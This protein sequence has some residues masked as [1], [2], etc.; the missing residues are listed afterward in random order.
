MWIFYRADAIK[1]FVSLTQL[2]G[3]RVN[4]GMR[5]SGTPGL[6]NRLLAANQVD[7]DELTRSSTSDQEAVLALL[8]GRLDALFLVA[9]PEAPYVQML[10]QTPGATLRV[11]PG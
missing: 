8:D 10:L 3:K 6:A 11:R 7:R 4:L 1:D 9:A 2:R 5:G